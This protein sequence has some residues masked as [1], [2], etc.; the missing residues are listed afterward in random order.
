[1]RK[2]LGAL[3]L[4]GILAA[5]FAVPAGATYW[6]PPRRA[7]FEAVAA[8]QKDGTVLIAYTAINHDNVNP[9]TGIVTVIT[10]PPTKVANDGYVYVLPDTLGSGSITVPGTFAGP[11]TLRIN[12]YWK[13][14]VTD[15]EQAT[16]SLDGKCTVPVTTGAPT[17]TVAPATQAAATAAAGVTAKFTG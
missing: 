15:V 1:M 8:C 3:L 4:I 5:L 17:T 10:G 6:A 12:V 9:F 7:T 14:G 11:V 16:V 2:F 13:D